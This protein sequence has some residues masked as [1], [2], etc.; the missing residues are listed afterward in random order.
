MH[1]P[2][3][4][5]DRRH[6]VNAADIIGWSSAAVLIATIGT[7][8]ARQWKERSIEGVSPWLYVGQTVASSGL[9]AYSVL[10]RAWVFVALNIVMV[11]A[12]IVGLALYISL[13]RR[14]PPGRRTQRSVTHHVRHRP[15]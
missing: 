4:R 11:A 3:L 8:I 12:A 1:A 13:S 14:K 10:T 7:Q 9:L 2:D 15:V 5:L 6:H